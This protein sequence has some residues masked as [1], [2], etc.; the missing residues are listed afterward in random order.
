[1]FCN[2]SHYIVIAIVRSDHRRELFGAGRRDVR[3][4]MA[5]TEQRSASPLASPTRRRQPMFDKLSYTSSGW[6]ASL[7][8]LSLV[9]FQKLIFRLLLR[10]SLNGMGLLCSSRSY[11][12]L[13]VQCQ[14]SR[15]PCI[16]SE[17][18]N[19]RL[20]NIWKNRH[21]QKKCFRQ[22]IVW[23]EGGGKRVPLI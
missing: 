9:Q 16:Q 19:L 2:L 7:G 12:P 18:F 11:L 1:M 5:G 6:S 13:Y 23:S 8:V 15:T 14:N 3:A 21:F 10:I 4:A 17:F 22:K 20:Q